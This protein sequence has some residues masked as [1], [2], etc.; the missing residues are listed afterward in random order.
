MFHAYGAPYACM[1]FSL[2]AFAPDALTPAN[3]KRGRGLARGIWLGK[4]SELRPTAACKAPKGATLLF[5]AIWTG[6]SPFWDVGPLWLTGAR[7]LCGFPPGPEDVGLDEHDDDGY[8]R[9]RWAIG[10]V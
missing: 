1:T 3:P 8:A 5:P 4:A 7:T 6:T 10:S 2:A 9:T